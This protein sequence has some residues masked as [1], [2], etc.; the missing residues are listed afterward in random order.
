[1]FTWPTTH[2]LRHNASYLYMS[3]YVVVLVMFLGVADYLHSASDDDNNDD[4][5]NKESKR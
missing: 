2:D 5:V 1:M 3:I 4:T